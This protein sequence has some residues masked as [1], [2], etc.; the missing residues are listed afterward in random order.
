MNIAV[1]YAGLARKY[2]LRIEVPESCTVGEGIE[3]SGILALC[4]D[5]QLESQKVGVFGKAVKLD[6]SLR[7]GDRIEIY[8]P[9]ICDPATVPRRHTGEDEE[10]EEE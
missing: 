8:R 2:W 10:G 7:P 6:A 5:I 4:P 9:I 3:R 1:A